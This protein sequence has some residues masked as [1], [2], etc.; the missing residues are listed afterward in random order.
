[1]YE[2]IARKRNEPATIYCGIPDRLNAGL[3]WMYYPALIGRTEAITPRRRAW[4]EAMQMRE[5]QRLRLR[6]GVAE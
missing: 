6:L 1:M 3:K 4:I 5:E 2:A